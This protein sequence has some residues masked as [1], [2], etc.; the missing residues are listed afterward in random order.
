MTDGASQVALVP[1]EH[2]N[3]HF[4]PVAS[5]PK[6]KGKYILPEY[7]GGYLETETRM[8]NSMIHGLM[9]TAD[10]LLFEMRQ[11]ETQKLLD[12]G[13]EPNRRADHA[14]HKQLPIWHVDEGGEEWKKLWGSGNVHYAYSVNDCV[15]RAVEKYIH[16]AGLGGFTIGD[17]N[18][19][20]YHPN[21][22]QDGALKSI[23]LG[24]AHGLLYPYGLGIDRVYMPMASALGK[25]HKIFAKALGMNPAAIAT[26][27]ISNAEFIESLGEDID[28]GIAQGI[29]NDCRFEFV[30]KPPVPCVV[31]V[32]STITKFKKDKSKGGV[33]V[34]GN[35]SSTSTGLGH[36]DYLGARDSACGTWLIAFQ[37]NKLENIQ[38]R[39]PELISG[40]DIDVSESKEAKTSAGKDNGKDRTQELSVYKSKIGG[41][42]VDDLAEKDRVRVRAGATQAAKKTTEEMKANLGEEVEIADDRFV[43]VEGR[44]GDCGLEELEAVDDVVFCACG[45]WAID[46]VEEDDLFAP[47]GASNDLCPICDSPVVDGYCTACMY[48][49]EHWVKSVYRFCPIHGESPYVSD[50]GKFVCPDCLRDEG[51]DPLAFFESGGDMISS[52]LSTGM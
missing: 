8:A 7:A 50:Q 17:K 10:G 6:P 12:N 45:W 4:G 46:G 37:I 36:A 33:N 32:N 35:W 14:E 3:Q 44:C 30:D 42:S 9:L 1:M 51:I 24:V 26:S 21:V 2:Y 41:V 5:E 27:S 38:Y 31:L 29:V 28:P 52:M 40:F 13:V 11:Y 18:W 43:S 15:F 23:V 20:K 34:G 22:T 49:P 19:F 47:P 16:H 48:S 25:E 39:K